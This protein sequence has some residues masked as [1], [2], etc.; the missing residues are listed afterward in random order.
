MV[1]GGSGADTIFGGGGHADI[2]DGSG[3]T[4]V[5]AGPGGDYVQA[6]TGQA[7]V[8][9]GTGADLLGFVSGHG[10]GTDLISGFKASGDRILLQ[11]FGADAVSAVLESARIVG[12]DTMLRLADNTQITFAN[13]TGLARSSFA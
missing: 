6:G 4:L 1:V 7:T 13:F 8:L 5:V 12:H 9:A 11:G 2:F 10:G 3:S